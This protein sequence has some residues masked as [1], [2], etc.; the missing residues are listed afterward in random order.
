ME[1]EETIKHYE[2]IAEREHSNAQVYDK[3]KNNNLD[4]HDKITCEKAVKRHRECA[5][6]YR[7][8]AEW[9]KIL[10][11]AK[12]E[13]DEAWLTITHPTPDITY[14]DKQRAQVILDKFRNSLGAIS[15]LQTQDVNDTNVGDMVS[16]QNAI[17]ALCSK[18]T[19]DKPETCSTIQKN[20]RWCEEVYTLLNLPST[21][22]EYTE[23]TPEEAASEIAR[24]STMPVSYWL[25][26]MIQLKQMGYAICR[27]KR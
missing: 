6:E 23:L 18:C 26:D 22:S 5:T 4:Y 27:K 19:V 24:G 11:S 25:D 8:L 21:Q 15:A 12:F 10:K 14:A 1:L 7:Q 20:D 17:D 9:L 16:R 2:K 13:Y 3:I